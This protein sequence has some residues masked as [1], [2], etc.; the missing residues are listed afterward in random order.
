MNMQRPDWLLQMEDILETLNEGVMILDDCRDILFINSCL[1]KMFG[2]P[3]SE[4]VGHNGISFYTEEERKVMAGHIER[5]REA[6]QNR[7]EFVLP[8]KDGSRLPVIISSRMFEDP[9]GLQFLVVTF[10]DISEQKQSEAE[11]RDANVKLERRQSEIEE[12]L[13]L[14]ARVQQSLAPQ[15]LVWGGMRVD[16]YFHPVR[17]I[18]GDFGL[19][20]PI[21]D[22]HLNLLV[23]DVSGHGIGSALVANRIYSETMSQLRSG[24]PLSEMLRE[25]NRFVMQ[26][27]GSSA[28]LFTLAAARIDLGGRRMIFAG[29]GHPPAMIVTPGEQPRLLESRSMVLGGLSDAVATEAA[30]EVDLNPGDRVVLYT[31]GISEVFD[32][33]G[34]MLGTEGVQK[35][36][37]ETALLPFGDMQQ[38]MLNRVAAWRDGA[39]TDDMSLVLVEVV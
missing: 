32:S 28:L 11:L 33:S 37:R 21:D 38:A 7:F 39:P 26:N 9:D 22:R 36:V 35:I 29:A 15:S 17:S 5:G 13:L 20:S 27:L 16:A 1:E 3:A 34:E 6:G 23:C 31:D 19:V 30:I 12:D 4:V 14:A 8:V 10:T 18:G 24:A 2:F 25:L